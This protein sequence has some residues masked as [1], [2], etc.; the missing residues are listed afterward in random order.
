MLCTC[1]LIVH[2]EVAKPAEDEGA[3]KHKL[4]EKK[5]EAADATTSA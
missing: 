2:E 3:E 4:A 1:D 5:A